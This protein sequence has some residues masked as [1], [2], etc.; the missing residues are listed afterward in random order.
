MVTPYN[1]MGA[2]PPGV[3]CDFLSRY[4]MGWDQRR[5]EHNTER[6]T[7]AAEMETKRTTTE[8]PVMM[9]WENTVEP[10]TDPPFSNVPI[11]VVGPVNSNEITEWSPLTTLWEH[12]LQILAI[13][14][15]GC[16]LAEA[17]NLTRIKAFHIIELESDASDAS[18]CTNLQQVWPTQA[19]DSFLKDFPSL[20]TEGRP[21]FQWMV[22]TYPRTSPTS[23]SMDFQLMEWYRHTIRAAEILRDDCNIRTIM[24][25]GPRRIPDTCRALKSDGI[26]NP[27]T[28]WELKTTTLCNTPHG[29]AIET[30]HQVM[31]LT[32]PGTVRQW[33]P[34]QATVETATGMES[35]IGFHRR[36]AMIP[37]LLQ[38]NTTTN[39]A[40]SG[41]AG[42]QFSSRV[43]KHVRLR[44]QVGGT[45]GIPAYDSTGPAPSI[46]HAIMANEEF[47]NSPFEI[48]LPEDDEQGETCRP[49]LKHEIPLLLGLSENS[50][51]NKEAVRKDM[52]ES[53]CPLVFWDYCVERRARIN[54]LTAKSIFKLHGSN[55]HTALTGEEGDISNLC[56]YKW[57][58]WC[59]FLEHKAQFPHP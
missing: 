40:L 14:T 21:Q 19:L 22:A 41:T 28:K 18:L 55:A 23:G 26:L 29:G 57:Y 33:D 11:Q 25:I 34:P 42:D 20:P 53:N 50:T 5:E 51:H 44:R 1:P 4:N 10:D 30:E 48:W 49:I 12:H 52:K 27:W 8:T 38:L 39:T 6:R 43:V 7:Q 31:C 17:L 54:N 37:Q 13:D 35:I 45:R 36:N 9:A 59:Y 24:L 32:H 46:A 16:P 56:Q 15:I 58:D 3:E 2:P 47:F